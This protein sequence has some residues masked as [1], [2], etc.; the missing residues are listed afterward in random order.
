MLLQHGVYSSEL[1]MLVRG[2]TLTCNGVVWLYKCLFLQSAYHLYVVNLK[3]TY[4]IVMAV[5]L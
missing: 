3:Q 2:M 5:D 1:Y 4:F